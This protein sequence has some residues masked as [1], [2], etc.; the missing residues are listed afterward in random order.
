MST[1]TEI[2]AAAIAALTRREHA[3]R[4]LMRKLTTK[5]FEPDAVDGVLADLERE[6]L[7]SDERF[8]EVYV[9][10]RASRGY[11]PLRIRLELRERGVD[12]A[13][14]TTSLRDCMIDWRE[15]ARDAQRK[16]FVAMP[17]SFPERAR[18]SRFLQRRGF[19]SEQLRH[20]LAGD[21]ED[22]AL[23]HAS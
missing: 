8:A 21:D 15:A 4:E 1:E 3:T 6:G 12:D 9:A 19:D 17:D 18:Q 13:L 23:D 14:I 7:L 16:R 2:R 11:G 22:F 20:A 5:G 10:Q